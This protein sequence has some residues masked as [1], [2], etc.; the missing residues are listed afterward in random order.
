[1]IKCGTGDVLH[2]QSE[3]FERLQAGFDQR[4]VKQ[5]QKHNAKK[6]I[7]TAFDGWNLTLPEFNAAP[8]VALA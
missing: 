7:L 2:R 1:M 6:S 8:A 3:Y 4:A 5:D